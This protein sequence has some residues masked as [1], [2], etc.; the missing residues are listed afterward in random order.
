VKSSR[1][2]L[3]GAIIGGTIILLVGIFQK[4]SAFA[5]S[6]QEIPTAPQADNYPR[7]IATDP[8]Q[9]VEPVEQ[10]TASPTV[11]TQPEIIITSTVPSPTVTPPVLLHDQKP[12]VIGTSVNGLPLEIY[13][14]GSGTH[15]RMIV[16]G[17]HGG[18]EWNTVT[19]ANQLIA[20]V[21]QTPQ[22]VP[23]DVTLYILRNLNPDGETRSHDK[24]GRV[25]SHGVDLNR[26]FPF[27]WQ[28][29]WERAG[30]WNYLPTSGGSSAG[31]EPETQALVSFLGSHSIE[32][33]ISYHSAALGVFPGGVPWDTDSVKFA[34]AIASVSSYPFPPLDTGCAYTGTLADYSVSTGITAVDL[35]L[36]N[37]IETDFDTNLRVLETL[38]TF[39][40]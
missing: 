19:L 10:V 30:C 36:T 25:N 31:S 12:E 4:F 6:E 23:E 18:D 33:L 37:H 32:T 15:G 14:F 28:K 20:Y 35:E 8:V 9:I 27:N 34:E 5:S 2:F 22:V 24:Y 7:L 38:L 26:N 11:T 17:I 40:P 1:L 16:A 21:N 13:T 3:L 29:D 39:Q